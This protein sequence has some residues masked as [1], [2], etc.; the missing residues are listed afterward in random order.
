MKSI[1][2]TAVLAISLALGGCAAQV[3]QGADEAGD[4]GEATE[5]FGCGGFGWTGPPP[6]VWWGSYGYSIP[7]FCDGTGAAFSPVEGDP[8]WL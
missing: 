4:V 8:P 2:Y 5:A 6:G 7:Y 1:G 3:E